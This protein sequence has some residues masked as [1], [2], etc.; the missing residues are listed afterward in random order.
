MTDRIQKILSD[1]G[2]ASR[3]KAEQMILDGRVQC[4]GE[5]CVLGQTAD[6]LIDKILVDGNPLPVREERVYIVLHKPKGYVTTLSDER[7]RK[8]VAEK[9]RRQPVINQD[10]SQYMLRVQL[11][12]INHS[13]K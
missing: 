7:G 4:N 2:I 3:R 10:K 9:L 12:N 11:M 5:I 6:P 8:T 1:Y 13:V